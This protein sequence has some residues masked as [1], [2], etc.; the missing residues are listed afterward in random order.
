MINPQSPAEPDGVCVLWTKRFDFSVIVVD[1]SKLDSVIVVAGSK[2]K[3]NGW[4]GLDCKREW[5]C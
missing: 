5:H 4:T 1:G 2:L 3:D